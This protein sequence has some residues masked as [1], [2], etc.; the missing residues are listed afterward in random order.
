MRL[1]LTPTLT[2]TLTPTL[3]LTLTQTLTRPVLPFT[4]ALAALDML[5]YKLL[6]KVGLGLG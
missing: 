1:T 5:R 4:L 6:D 3:T 2:L